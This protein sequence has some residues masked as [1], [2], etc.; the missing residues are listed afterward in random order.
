MPRFPIYAGFTKPKV[1]A[2]VDDENRSRLKAMLESAG[3]GVSNWSAE[4]MMELFYKG[5]NVELG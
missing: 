3:A 1:D 5:E 2:T 4:A